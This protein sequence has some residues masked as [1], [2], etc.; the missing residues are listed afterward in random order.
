MMKDIHLTNTLQVELIKIASPLTLHKTL[1][2]DI[3]NNAKDWACALVD[4]RSLQ[5][6]TYVGLDIKH[7]LLEEK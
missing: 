6:L 7:L 2:S 4:V 1:N 3:K 5:A